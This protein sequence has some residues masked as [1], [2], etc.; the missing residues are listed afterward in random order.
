[1]L[2]AGTLLGAMYAKVESGELYLADNG[3]QLIHDRG[4]RI[5]G[6]VG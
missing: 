4:Y 2:V 5:Q 6:H 3:K 1:M